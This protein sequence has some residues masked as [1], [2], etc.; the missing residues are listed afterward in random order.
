[1]RLP[2][3]LLA[4][5]LLAIVPLSTASPIPETS[6]KPQYL[7][8]NLKATHNENYGI[9]ALA[10]E[11]EEIQS[12]PDDYL[13]I[14]YVNREIF[15]SF[16]LSIGI[17]E[18]NVTVQVDT[19]SSD[20]WVVGADVNCSPRWQSDPDCRKLGTFDP[21]QSCTWTSNDTEFNIRYVDGSYSRGVWG[22]D[23]IVL[24]GVKIE[25]LSF[26]V[27]SHA[28]SSIAV[29]GIGL[30]SLETTNFVV[31]QEPYAYDNLPRLLQRNGLIARNAYSLYTNR[32]SA[33]AGSIVFGGVDHRK[34]HG[35]LL[36]LP[37]VNVQP[38]TDVIRTLSIIMTE[39][40]FNSSRSRTIAFDGKIGALLDSGT[41]LSYFPRQISETLARAAGAIWSNQFNAFVGFCPSPDDKSKLE[42][43][44]NGVSISVPIQ[45]FT[46]ETGVANICLY[47]FVP[48]E[49]NMVILGDI[50]LTAAYI[51]YD[52]D[53]LEVSM[54]QARY[55][56]SEHIEPIID[57][58]PRAEKAPG[59]YNTWDAP[60]K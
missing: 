60:T 1:M 6:V 14:D 12:R 10:R 8:L 51:V 21:N 26:A 25:G 29:L 33:E 55:S 9:E 45:D 34:Y 56:N 24:D 58:V 53:R 39:V 28:T 37:L 47:L 43:E 16:D 17:P 49:R 41:T 44:F 4:G 11:V 32:L 48:W 27:A 5:G 22:M 35:K 2:K 18:Q 57:A 50:F 52:L 7:R 23:D 19:G 40:A 3:L 59:Y 42:F 38:T 20:L 30:P 46:L 15:Y 36:T 31:G 13:K 54:A